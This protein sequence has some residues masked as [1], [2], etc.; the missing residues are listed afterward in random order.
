MTI[1]RFFEW[2]GAVLLVVFIAS[3]VIAGI[4]EGFRKGKDDEVG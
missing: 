2:A 1:I 4:I 3:A